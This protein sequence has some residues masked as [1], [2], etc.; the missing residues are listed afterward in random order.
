MVNQALD[1][2][3][4][5]KLLAIDLDGTLLTD[6]KKITGKTLYCL[7]E[8]KKYGAKICIATA[9][10]FDSAKRVTDCYNL[11]LPIICSNG[12]LI[13]ESLSLNEY[14]LVT[15]KS[16]DVEQLIEHANEMNIPISFY[17]E[18][19]WYI[20]KVTQSFESYGKRNNIK[21]C[22]IN[23]AQD[24]QDLRILKIMF[25]GNHEEMEE[26][27]RWSKK[28]NLELN[29]IYSDDCCIDITHKDASKGNALK[30]LAEIF[31]YKKQEIIV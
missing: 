6:D 15:I 27:E 22:L 9:R 11:D 28:N 29:L 16:K 1:S 25:R 24:L 18:K 31:G 26:V 30:K 4:L 12:A 3:K 13:K 17:T 5:R 14:H 20:N 2:N 7:H 8:V 21:A 19:D 10:T 23:K